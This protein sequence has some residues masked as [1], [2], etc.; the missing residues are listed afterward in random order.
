MGLIVRFYSV[1]NVRAQE[2]YEPDYFFGISGENLSLFEYWNRGVRA[3]TWLRGRLIYHW[4][5]GLNYYIRIRLKAG[6]K[7]DILMK[8]FALISKCSKIEKAK[9]ACVTRYHH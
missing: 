1:L 7:I 2:V 3:Y 4:E 6:Q 8:T 9:A 5:I